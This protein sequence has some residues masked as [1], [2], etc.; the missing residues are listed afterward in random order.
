[1][2]TVQDFV[3]L[4]DELIKESGS[5]IKVRSAVSRAYYGAYHAAKTF[6]DEL[7]IKGAVLHKGCGI[8]EQLIQCLENPM[9][10]HS[11]QLYNK[12]KSLGFLLRRVRKC[13]SDADYE[14]TVSFP[15]ENA[16]TSIAEAKKIIEKSTSI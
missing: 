5:P 14:I 12:S 1:M 6:H 10:P 13:R 16:K 3:T 7:P 9:V 15:I 4:A 8:H 11:D 2:V